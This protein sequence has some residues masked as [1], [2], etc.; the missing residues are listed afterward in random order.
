MK[1]IGIVLIILILCS[2]SEKDW[3]DQYQ[4]T[5]M[6][7]LS[8]TSISGIIQNDNE[9]LI[10]GSHLIKGKFPDSTSSITSQT[11]MYVLQSSSVSLDNY[12]GKKVL[13][14]GKMKKG[15][16]VDYGQYYME[17]DK[18]EIEK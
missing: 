7:T 2:C 13:V 15:Y 5:V 4:P 3:N 6:K 11:K 12:K 14:K 10:N 17:V 18:I 9:M 1:L 16:P 8:E